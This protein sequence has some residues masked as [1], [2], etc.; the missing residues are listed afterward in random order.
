MTTRRDQ[1]NLLRI[2]RASRFHG[3]PG[4]A[5]AWL[6][7]FPSVHRF[8]TPAA[9]PATSCLNQVGGVSLVGGRTPCIRA[10]ITPQ[11]Y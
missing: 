1:G 3:G 7:G 9:R 4:G 11:T 5:A 2:A 8:V 6:A 10:I